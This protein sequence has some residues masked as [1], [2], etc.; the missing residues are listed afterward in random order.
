LDA[1]FA[2]V[3]VVKECP[4]ADLGFGLL[5]VEELDDEVAGLP[6]TK[7]TLPIPAVSQREP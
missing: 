1:C 4:G 2:A 6:Q 7:K 5:E 3:V